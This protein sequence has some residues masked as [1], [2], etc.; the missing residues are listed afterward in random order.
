[1][2]AE[3]IAALGVN[4]QGFVFQAINFLVLLVVLRIFAYPSIIRALEDRKQKIDEQLK[5]ANELEQK[6]ALAHQQAS[7][8]ID[9]SHQKAKGL[10][11]DAH[12]R[13]DTILTD[14]RAK[15]Q[16]ETA[17]MVQV[18]QTRIQQ[19]VEQA[20]QELRAET[21]ALVVS[22]TEKILAEKITSKED[23]AIIERALV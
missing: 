12:A 6:L 13:A 16:Q 7:D 11:V 4:F 23:F 17:D 19:E 20:K 22:A 1:M 15:T 9:S 5:N 14:A 10:I 3:G 8:I 21:V 18:A 2:P